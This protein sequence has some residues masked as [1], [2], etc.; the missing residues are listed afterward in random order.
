MSVRPQ[1]ERALARMGSKSSEAP[2][3]VSE[4]EPEVCIKAGAG[5]AEAFV[6]ALDNREYPSINIEAAHSYAPTRRNH[7]HAHTM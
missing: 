4:V 1:A 2:T 3:G 7:I 6:R 5:S